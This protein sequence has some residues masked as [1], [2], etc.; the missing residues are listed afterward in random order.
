M[1]IKKIGVLESIVYG[2]FMGIFEVVPGISG[3]T[4]A[5]ILGIYELLIESISNLKKDFK[6]SVKIL[7]PSLIGMG[8]GVY[9]F[10]FLISYFS[11][12]TPMEFNFWLT[13]LIVGIV[14][15]IW[16]EAVK[17]FNFSVSKIK[18]EIE[19]EEDKFKKLKFLKTFFCVLSLV[20]TLAV[21]FV[22]NYLSFTLTENN[23][24]ITDLNFLQYVRFFS[25]GALASFCLMLPGCSGSLMML[26]FGIYYTVINAI[27]NLNFLV[28]APAGLGILFGL[29]V[30]SKIINFCLKN[31]R[32]QTFFAILG[33]VVGSCASPF[34]TFLKSS[35]KILNLKYL[36]YHGIFSILLLALGCVFSFAF[37]KYGEKKN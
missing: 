21:M 6:N 35:L 18:N 14:P 10:S 27:H 17:N 25:V 29:L 31:F 34:L 2:I 4:L 37:S 5:F 12:K 13:G 36:T 23:G 9:F 20:L 26:V 30:G 32:A 15:S 19:F 33:L 3:G 16:K 11:K 28:L 24:I 1:N 7:L 8:I 22:V